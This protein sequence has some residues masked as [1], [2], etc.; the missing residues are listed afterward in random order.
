MH[1][2]CVALS[3]LACP[4][5]QTASCQQVIVAVPQRASDV[6][7]TRRLLPPLLPVVP[8]FRLVAA[9]EA[10]VTK[11]TSALPANR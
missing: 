3:A 10:G 1:E 5:H 11:R 2:K 6:P 4:A 9:S 7:R 8:P